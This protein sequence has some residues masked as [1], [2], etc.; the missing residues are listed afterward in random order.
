[1]AD[2]ETIEKIKNLESK[3]KDLI[4]KKKAT[5]IEK[6]VLDKNATR[7]DEVRKELGANADGSLGV[8]GGKKYEGLGSRDVHVLLT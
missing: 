3:H 1:M 5:K 7:Y 6:P 2:R 4:S 8:Y